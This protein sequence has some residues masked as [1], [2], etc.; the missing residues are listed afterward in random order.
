MNRK[1]ARDKQPLSVSPDHVRGRDYWRSLEELA[2]SEEFR[3]LLRSESTR[4]SVLGANAIDRREFLRLM[5][6]SLALAGLAACAHPTP[7]EEKI[8]PFVK[9]PENLI[10]GKPRFFATAFTHHGAATGVLVESHAGRPTKVEGNPLHPAS[11]GATD[12]FAQA[13]ILSLY[14]PDR[15]QIVTNAGALNTWSAFAEALNGELE[16]QR[17]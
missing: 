7:P 15:S 10:P 12:A 6:A 5:G 14:D 9:Q 8:V 4:P 11:L 17:P 13:S 2:D 16:A 1:T 3:E